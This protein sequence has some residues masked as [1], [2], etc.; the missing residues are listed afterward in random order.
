MG[1]KLKRKKIPGIYLRNFLF[2]KIQI[3]SKNL[4]VLANVENNCQFLKV[5]KLSK[6]SLFQ[7]I[8]FFPSSLL[9]SPHTFFLNGQ[10]FIN[11]FS[12]MWK[13]AG[14]LKHA[15]KQCVCFSLSFKDYFC[16]LNF[17]FSI[18]LCWFWW[19][20]TYFTLFKNSFSPP[21]ILFYFHVQC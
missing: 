5:T 16:V 1:N 7:M 6:N 18:F 9:A 8:P 19:S 21:Q 20:M 4:Y 17:P 10:S 13:N 3:P 11:V 14:I 15:R 2:I 12:K